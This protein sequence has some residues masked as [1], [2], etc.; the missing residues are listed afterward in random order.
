VLEVLWR[1]SL[2]I[3]VKHIDEQHKML[4]A[5]TEEL[6]KEI[7]KIGTVDKEKCISAILFL[8]DYSISHFQDE[9]KYWE[10]IQR[11]HLDAHKKLHENFLQTVLAHEQKMLKSDFAM[12]EVSEFV[13]MLAAWL[14][15]HVAEEDQISNYDGEAGSAEL[16]SYPEMVAA[17]ISSILEKMTDANPDL[18]KRT[19]AYDE[20]FSD[21]LCIKVNFTDGAVGHLT[22]IYPL[23][24]AKN[25]V[26]S[27]LNLFPEKIGDLEMSVLYELTN[28]ISGTVCTGIVNAKKTS[29][30]IKPPVLSE[31]K[32]MP[33]DELIVLDTERGVIAALIA[34]SF[35]GKL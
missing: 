4:F 33:S 21:A 2:C 35:L 9:E 25:L 16:L 11:A 17:G 31:I 26:L 8:K 29:F 20:S 27:I 23:P 14:L 5:K 32:R 28:I 15:Y 34:I 19:D 13:G 30:D 6:I 3:G 22:V 7:R 18:I 10:A 24:F 12:K 1:E